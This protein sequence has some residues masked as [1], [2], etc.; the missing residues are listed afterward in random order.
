M[1]RDESAFT[2]RKRTRREFIKAAGAASAA[3]AL[4]IPGR[5]HGARKTLKIL[6]WNHFVPGY[7]EWFN[8]EYVARWGREN[9]T[10]VIVHNVGMSSL[11]S[12][13]RAE[14]SA[15]KGH[16]LFMFLRPSPVFEDEVIDHRDIYEECEARFGKPIDLA[17]RSTFNPKTGKYFGFSD[18]YTP[19]PVNY[20]KDLWDDVGIFP[21]SW[22]DIRTGG[23]KIMRKHRVP[24]GL[25]LAPELDSNMALRSL[26]HAFGA[27]VQDEEGNPALK[28]PET[29]EALKFMNAVYEESMTDEVFTWDPSSNNR[30]LLAGRGSLTL[31]AISITRTGENQKIP[32]A[33]RI[34][35]ARAAQGPAARIGLQH[36]VDTYTIWK[37]AENIDGAKQFLVD[38]VADFRSAFL[39]SE[40]YNFPCFPSTVP[41]L[42][43]LIAADPKAQPQDKYS[44]FEDVTDWMTNV[45]YPGYANAAIDELFSNSTVTKMFAESA[46]GKMSPS[47]AMNAADAEVRATF[48]RW[49]ELGKV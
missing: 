38:Y 30:L 2:A 4:I 10:R 37:F 42:S 15:G 23:S 16:D 48:A 43:A 11:Q 40:F 9:D 31:N 5:A 7:D 1:S 22:D 34:W 25:G 6:Q 47:D 35:L 8:N 20:R 18:S 14:V 13:A 29:L 41:D 21:G 45:G 49:R 3:P 32:V 19:D 17:L 24:M 12:R 46:R 33:D 26:L 44:I 28:S 27:S 39:A 36:L